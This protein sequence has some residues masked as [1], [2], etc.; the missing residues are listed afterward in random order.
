MYEAT[1]H[2]FEF[3]AVTTDASY[4]K[5]AFLHIRNT[6]YIPAMLDKYIWIT[7][8]CILVAALGAPQIPPITE[9]QQATTELPVGTIKPNATVVLIVGRDGRKRNITGTVRR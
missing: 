8:V 7:I 9:P 3:C 5:E 4:R 2:K 1:V 6:V